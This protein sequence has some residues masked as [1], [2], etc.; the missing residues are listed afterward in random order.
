MA[1]A[2]PALAA[3]I[4]VGNNPG[5]CPNANYP[6]I[7]SA[8]TAASPGD[9]IVVCPGTYPEQVK[10]PAGK[11]NLTLESQKPLQAIIQ[12]PPVMT[13][14]KAI[15]HVNGAK[16]TAIRKFTIQGPGGGPCDSLEYGVRV[17]NGGSAEITANRIAHIRDEPFSGCQN[18][19]AILVG[20]QAE[21]T[22]G[23]ASI[24]LNLI[25]DYQKGGIA[26]GNNG[27][28]AD[29]AFNLIRGVGSTP[30]I[31]ANGIQVAGGA[32]A[33]VTANAVSDNLY[34]PQTVVSTGILLFQPGK[35]DVRSNRLDSNDVGIY[36]Y[37]T[38]ARTRISGNQVSSST[39]DGIL[40]DTVTKTRV[41]DNESSSNDQGIGVYTTTQAVVESN[42]TDDNTTT[43][44][45]AWTDT[46]N[47]TFSN[48]Q[49]SNNGG[50]DCQDDSHGGGTA[51]TANL[52]V[53][54][55][56]VKSS[57]PGICMS[58]GR[59]GH[60]HGHGDDDHGWHRNPSRD[61]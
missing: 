26:V 48:N 22:T 28:Y 9:H 32:D 24:R 11:D 18:G 58:G 14:P 31:A 61:R 30:T 54:N 41:E 38:D 20:R 56:G 35:V 43:G 13:A 17:D 12:A 37:G 4:K 55:R 3:D 36:S 49:A 21:G 50:F 39:F 16:R 6:T 10:I 2:G 46:S 57:P 8:V 42:E 27:S 5:N 47:N 19:V 33:D 59:P 45:Y 29:I 23:T 15:V 1:F 52:W 25:E 7:Q 53:R 40:L 51:G 60:G 44:I 34:S